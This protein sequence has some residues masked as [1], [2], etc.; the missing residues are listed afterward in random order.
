MKPLIDAQSDEDQDVILKQILQN[1]R[2]IAVL[3]AS[4]QENRPSCRITAYL[5][6]QGYQVIPVNP[7]HN[8]ILDQPTYPDLA[9]IPCTVD[10]ANV[11]RRA[12]YVPDIVRQVRESAIHVLWLQEGII[13]REAAREAAS[14]GVQVVMDRCIYRDHKRLIHNIPMGRI[15][16]DF[17]IHQG[18]SLEDVARRLGISAKDL[19]LLENNPQGKISPEMVQRIA[20]AIED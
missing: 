14:A 4:P 9:H 13:H 15:L 2:T 1:V 3:G 8:R 10:M 5:I 19:E 6:E 7:A 20:A 17:R 11:F 12:E 16:A 18:R